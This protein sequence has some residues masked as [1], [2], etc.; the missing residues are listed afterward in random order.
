MWGNKDGVKRACNIVRR[1]MGTRGEDGLGA[2]FQTA[3]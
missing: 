3:P 2:L 1:V